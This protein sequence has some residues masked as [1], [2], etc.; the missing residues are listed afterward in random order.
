MS[1]YIVKYDIVVDSSKVAAGVEAFNKA[2]APLQAASERIA[3]LSASINELS[4]A[5]KSMKVIVD[6]TE[7]NKA[8]D[9]LATKVT[10]L[11]KNM[12]LIGKA[13]TTKQRT[14][15]AKSTTSTKTPAAK[16]A[17]GGTSSGAAGGMSYAAAKAANQKP[18]T[19]TPTRAL[20]TYGAQYR[21]IGPTPI[22]Q[23]AGIVDFVKGMGIMYGITG[24]GS[25]IGGAI[26]DS[27]EYNNIIQTTKNILQS[28]DARANFSGRFS[29]M[30]SIIRR[31]GV[32]TKFTA[33][34]VADASKFLAMAGFDIDAIGKSIRSIA[35]IALV[36]DTDLGETAD[37]VT[38]IMTGYGIR[39]EDIRHAADVMTQ[40]FTMSNTTL[41][42]IAES[43][44]YAASMLS[45]NGTSFEEAT[46]AIGILGD[47]GIKG[48]QAGT[49]LRSIVANIAKPTK[50]QQAMWDKLGINRFDEE[51]NLKGLYEI[52]SELST[53]NIGVTQLY[54][55]FHRTAVQGAASLI[56][57]VDKWN[58]IVE[59]NFMS[60]G[61]ASKL[62]NEKKNTIQGL[63]AQLTSAF[64]EAGMQAFE[65]QEKSIRTI[66]AEAIGWVKSENAVDLIKRISDTIMNLGQTLLKF[67]K[68][69]VGFYEKFEGVLTAY[70]K[71]QLFF[72][73][74]SFLVSTFM[75]F[76]NFSVYLG[77]LVGQAAKLG[78]SL[79]NVAGGMRAIAAADVQNIGN[80]YAGDPY[81]MAGRKI[82]A[83]GSVFDFRG[84]YRGSDYARKQNPYYRRII[85]KLEDRGYL[86]L[87]FSEYRAVRNN[88]G[89]P[90]TK[91]LYSDFIKEHPR[92]NASRGMDMA[93][94]GRYRSMYGITPWEKTT[95]YF[96]NASYKYGQSSMAGLTN[97]LSSVGGMY[98]GSILGSKIG[99]EGSLVNGLT[100]IAGGAAG[101]Y[102]LPKLMPLLTTN[103]VGIGIS[104]AAIAIGTL[105]GVVHRYREVTEQA[106]KATLEFY[107]NQLGF[108]QE[109]T[110]MEK[111]LAKV[112]KGQGDV[113][114]LLED[115]LQM[116][117]EE[118][119]LAVKADEDSG[120]MADEVPEWHNQFQ[121]YKKQ[122]NYWSNSARWWGAIEEAA[123][124]NKEYFGFEKDGSIY[125]FG[126]GL[127]YDT[128]DSK[129]IAERLAAFQFL[130]SIGASANE[131]G[132]VNT[133]TS[134]FERKLAGA[135]T[136]QDFQDI[137]SDWEEQKDKL[138]EQIVPGS[139][140]WR[141]GDLYNKSEA[142][143]RNSYDAIN[144][145]LKA[146]NNWGESQGFSELRKILEIFAEGKD[147]PMGYLLDY[148]IAKGSGAA[149][150]AKEF[151]LGTEGFYNKFGWDTKE[152]K[153]VS[154]EA[155]QIFGSFFS[156]MKKAIGGLNPVVAQLF[157]KILY[158]DAWFPGQTSGLSTSDTQELGG[159][160]YKWNG[161]EWVPMNHV[162]T[163][164]PMSN[165]AMNA[166]L[167]KNPYGGDDSNGTYTPGT[168]NPAPSNNNAYSN[169]Y[170]SNSA[171]PKQIIVKI[172]NLMNVESIDMNAPGVSGV[173]NNIKEQIADALIDVVSDFE[174]AIAQ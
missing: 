23:T 63:W 170:K 152:N 45:L 146:L 4:A 145:E 147:I 117:R 95:A 102:L 46:A 164:K 44:K 112:K 15:T 81:L 79:Y 120:R 140:D 7:A 113:N 131:G 70:L 29:N 85:G 32:D 130:T 88:W 47:A 35:D 94:L 16:S 5:M 161:T 111:Y 114:Q 20:T 21:A 101:A 134:V 143:L 166:A 68:I 18:A 72:K 60:D 128:A 99:P 118:L 3:K 31:V 98:L 53:K 24:L 87:P 91:E 26:R 133:I 119:G 172:E 135:K 129:G 69:L 37:V 2:I 25:L 150:A 93:V 49:I 6:T 100:T 154:S 116:R 137:M 67:T 64:T 162:G 11:K 109:E 105:V 27:A 13:G 30:E 90:A 163:A 34:Q 62:A 28:H 155:Q 136:Y 58:Q 173:I 65:S 14:T 153:F 50:N 57:H 42:E 19:T 132:S 141:I 169:N 56:T 83:K 158:N 54:S 144:A 38:N 75:S 61:L 89:Y 107:K 48:S 110:P 126:A 103:P 124:K 168:Y 171:T 151:G 51:G 10:N 17:S 139:K 160:T 121:N 39:P 77:K 41:M 115:Y 9:A 86:H 165:A 157:D 12:T 125:R 40:T 43:Y 82:F 142:E 127:E 123:E 73:G 138:R 59:E 106:N 174:V 159:V 55:M 104:L 78:P 52:F 66:L 167:G 74:G 36:G 149:L 1:E 92:M 97:V 22:T 148:L 84:D 122:F 108:A 71:L 96:R 80:K 33:P 8:I 76:K 156:E